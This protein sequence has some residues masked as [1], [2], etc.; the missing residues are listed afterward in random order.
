M[1]KASIDNY[2]AI[3]SKLGISTKDGLYDDQQIGPAYPNDAP[4]EFG[5][6]CQHVTA[7]EISKGII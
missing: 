2:R 6:E 5:E 7:D 4:A 1:T 3:A